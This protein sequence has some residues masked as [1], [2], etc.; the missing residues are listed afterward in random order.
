[1]IT[2]LNETRKAQPKEFYGSVVMIAV[3]FAFTYFSI[4]IF[5]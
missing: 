4:T 3:I 5:G 1:M 2:V